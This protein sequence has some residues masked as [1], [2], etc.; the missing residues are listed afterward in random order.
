MT[1]RVDDP[2]EGG[3]DGVAVV[4]RRDDRGQPVRQVLGAPGNLGGDEQRVEAVQ[5]DH[6]DET[7]K[8]VLLPVWMAAYKYG[9][10]SYRFVV[11]GQTGKVRGERPY[12]AWKIALAIL[13]AVIVLGVFALASRA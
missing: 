10:K 7:F 3:A 4:S 9:G 1:V 2:A 5:T 6:S 8:H 12:S 13:L 11:N